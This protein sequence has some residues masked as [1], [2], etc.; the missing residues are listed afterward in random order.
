[1]EDC[2]NH[3]LEQSFHWP[4]IHLYLLFH[5]PI[6]GCQG[7]SVSE[8]FLAVMPWLC[9]QAVQQTVVVQTRNVDH[10]PTL[11]ERATMPFHRTHWLCGPTVFLHC[12]APFLAIF[13]CLRGTQFAY[14][15]DDRR[16]ESAL[17][18]P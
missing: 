15:A 14:M 13:F 12:W 16:R 17:I 7:V 6:Y 8:I 11:W 2:T 1:M 9:P 5:W 4:T 3:K 18:A 10:N